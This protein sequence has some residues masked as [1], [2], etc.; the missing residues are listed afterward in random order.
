MKLKINFNI[1]NLLNY[2]VAILATAFTITVILIALPLTENISTNTSYDLVTKSTNYWAKEY[3]LLIHTHDE[4]KV[5]ETKNA[6]YRRVRKFGVE[7][8]EISTSP[9]ENEDGTILIVRIQTTKNQELVEQ[10]IKNQFKVRIV[11][12]KEDVDFQDEENQL[13]YLFLDSYN[14]TGWTRDDFRNIYITEL[15]TTENNYSYFAI[16]KLWP[17][18]Q[19]SFNDL[20]DQHRGD[21]IGVSNDAYVIPYLVPLDSQNIFAV[22]INAGSEQEAQVVKLLYNSGTIPSEITLL[23]AKDIEINTVNINHVGITIGLIISL[24]LSY[25]YLYITKQMQTEELKTTLFAT[26]LTASIYL[27]I[28]KLFFI[29]IDTFIL[30]ITAI[31]SF[32]LIKVLVENDDSVIYIEI[33]LLLIFTLVKIFSAGYINILATHL[34]GLIPLAKLTILFSEWYINKVREI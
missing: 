30:P 4:K 15:K 10:L 20:L 28:L 34:L 9:E 3:N 16:F 27:S 2:I 6:L 32:L 21:Y 8:V 23:S 13:A 11:A 25:G 33:L 12:R 5:Q 24:L 29:P 31:L 26:I 1:K 19:K 22:P 14:S 7:K 18:K 17:H